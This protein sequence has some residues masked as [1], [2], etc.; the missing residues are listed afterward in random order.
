M[1]DLYKMFSKK[2]GFVLQARPQYGARTVGIYA[3][4]SGAKIILEKNLNCYDK[5]P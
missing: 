4:Q 3:K 1:V 5:I 2:D